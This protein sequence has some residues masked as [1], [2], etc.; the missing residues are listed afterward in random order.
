MAAQTSVKVSGA[1]NTATQPYAK[2]SG[3]WQPLKQIWAKVSGT[4]QLVYDSFS[5][6]VSPTTLSGSGSTGVYVST[7]GASTCTPSGGTPTYTYLWVYVSGD[8]LTKNSPTSASCNFGYFNAIPGTK[9]G[10]FKCTVTDSASQVVDSNT[11][12][13]TITHF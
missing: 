13:A 2:V 10:V 12:T 3:T 9:V 7:S 4:W 6:S 5:A 8:T 11:V 1:W